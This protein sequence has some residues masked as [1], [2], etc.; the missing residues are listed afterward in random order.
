MAIPIGVAQDLAEAYGRLVPIW[1]GVALTLL[2]LGFATLITIV[3][4]S[5]V[6][7]GPKRAGRTAAY[8]VLSVSV[9]LLLS[10][11][12]VVVFMLISVEVAPVIDSVPLVR[13]LD[14]VYFAGLAVAP[15]VSIIAIIVLTVGRRSSPGQ[16]VVDAPVSE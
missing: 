12:L 13:G 14:R 15:V 1:P 6:A 10:Y 16:G 3:I 7:S 2:W 11:F 9:I 8:T 4:S 5:I